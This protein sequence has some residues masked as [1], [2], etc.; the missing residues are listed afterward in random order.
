MLAQPG[1]R[2]LAGRL[3]AGTGL[4]DVAAGWGGRQLEV[5]RADA[6]LPADL[7]VDTLLASPPLVSL[8]ASPPGLPLLQLMW[9][10]WDEHRSGGT[11]S[12]KLHVFVKVGGWVGGWARLGGLD[13]AGLEGGVLGSWQAIKPHISVHVGWVGGG[14][15]RWA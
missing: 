3:A 10:E 9:D 4:R 12:A 2:T 14:W 1:L 13:R 6:C 11:A 5:G 15:A 7:H 8:L